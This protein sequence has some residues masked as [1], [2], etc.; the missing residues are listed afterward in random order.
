MFWAARVYG[1]FSPGTFMY[2]S[3]TS[4]AVSLAWTASPAANRSAARLRSQASESGLAEVYFARY[5]ARV[6]TVSR[7]ASSNRPARR[8]DTARLLAALSVV[9]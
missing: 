5:R 7:W 9:G 3:T 1:C 2:W 8:S 4:W 6:A